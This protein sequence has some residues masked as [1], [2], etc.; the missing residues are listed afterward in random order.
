MLTLIVASNREGETLA[1][2]RRLLDEV[3]P[4][5]PTFEIK[6]LSEH[7][8]IMLFAPRMGAALL[9][10]MGLLGLLLA[11]VG[12]YGVVA[13]SVA[14]RTREIGVRLALGAG[15]GDVLGM[16]V[17]E[18][19][20]L[21]AVGVVLGVGLALLVTRALQGFLYG[22]TA[23]DPLTYVAVSLFLLAVAWLANFLPARRATGIDPILALRYE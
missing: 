13:Y 16:V 19:M 5:L 6:T 20:V 22:I 8:D 14:R 15:K 2:V 9:A 7:L 23:S 1:A 17:R 3:D 11:S 12:L 21:V 4:H 18:G 10:A